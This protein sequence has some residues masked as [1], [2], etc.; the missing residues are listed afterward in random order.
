MATLKLND[1]TVVTESGGTISAP[2]LNVTTGTL[3]SGVTFPSG[4]V[5]QMVSPAPSIETNALTTSYVN[6]YEVGITLKGGNSKVLIIFSYNYYVGSE[7]GLG[8]ELRKKTSSGVGT[9][10]TAVFTHGTGDGTGP[11]HVYYNATATYNQHTIHAVDDATSHSAG[12]T[13]YYGF[14]FKIRS[15]SG[16]APPDNAPDGY[17]SATLLEITA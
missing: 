5:I 4:H 2:A 15:N 14:F 17:F 6:L 13:I 7:S 12:N 11:L 10:D 1:Q 3:A 8:F 16:Y 9:S